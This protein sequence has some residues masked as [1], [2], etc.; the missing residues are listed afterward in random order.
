MSRPEFDIA[1]VGGA[2]VGAATACLLLREGFSVALI[3][4][5][6]PPTFDGDGPVGQR[7]SAISPGSQSV[8]GHAGAWR[9]VEGRRHCPYRRMH[10]EERDDGRPAV[11]EFAAA[12]FGLERLGTIVENDSIEEAL[13]RVLDARRTVGDEFEILRPARL[14]GMAPGESAMTISL[15][16][17]RCITAALV[18][19]ADGPRSPVREAAG[20]EQ[21]IWH[22]GQRGIVG[23]V[24]TQRPNPGVAWQRF[25]EGG[26]LAFLPLQ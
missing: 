11:I 25:M 5:R 24:E 8:L 16:S 13:W 21:N 20:I 6:E 3:E 10:V 26:P 14:E 19:G 22:Y 15:D 9:I 12:E 17:G 23:V 18:V 4:A 2:M 7:V 1:I